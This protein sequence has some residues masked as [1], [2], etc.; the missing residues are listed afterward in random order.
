MQGA[1]RDWD[2]AR[3]MISWEKSPPRNKRLVRICYIGE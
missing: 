2:S 1:D 3:P